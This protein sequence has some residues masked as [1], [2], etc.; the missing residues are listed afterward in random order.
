VSFGGGDMRA[1]PPLLVRPSR[2]TAPSQARGVR[3]KETVVAQEFNVRFKNKSSDEVNYVAVHPLAQVSG[4]LEENEHDDFVG[5]YALYAG[6]RV[7]TVFS[8]FPPAVKFSQTI[9]INQD[10][11]LI[12]ITDAGIQFSHSPPGATGFTE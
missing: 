6:P 10:Y 7:V 3:R 8:T 9:D 4:R 5:S 1:S 11:F 12:K 2:G